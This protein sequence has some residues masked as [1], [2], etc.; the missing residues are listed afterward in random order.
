MVSMTRA[1]LYLRISQDRSGQQAGVKRQRQDCEALAAARGWEVAGVYQDNDVSAYSR[2]PRPEF[3]RLMDDIAAG[4]IDAVVA[5]ATDRLYRRT[6]DL[7]RLVD[8]L[9]GI[10]VATVKSGDVD[11]STAD[12]RLRA[13]ILA[14]VAQHE[15]EKKGERVKAAAEQRARAG[16]YG[17][18]ARRMGFTKTADELVPDEADA[19]RE[20]YLHV[21][22][23]GSLESVAKDWRTRLGTGPR[24][25]YLTGVQVRD[26]LLR[27]MNAG[28][29]T[30]LG[31]EV[32]RTNG[33]AIIDEDTFRTV[34]A[35]LTDPKRRTRR[36]RP[37][38]T[39]LSGIMR[40]QYCGRP[41]S[42]SSRDGGR[43][44]PRVYTYACR[45]RCVSRR[46]HRMDELITELVLTRLERDPEGFI[47]PAT[48]TQG[49]TENSAA[50]EA[51]K[52]RDRL[53]ALAQLFAAGELEATDYAA[54]TR[55]ARARLADL[56]TKLAALSGT[57]NAARLLQ[58]GDVR[59]AWEASSM[60]QRRAIIREVIDHIVVG[61]GTSG[62]F[63][64][65]GLEIA[66]RGS[67]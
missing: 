58:S 67:E 60:E 18:G 35:I 31:D 24:G 4:R 39:L 55:Q 59:Q 66:W 50:V 13:R 57:P 16:G 47:E 1:A 38:E 25:G 46:R 34:R 51:E 8:G 62:K 22:G 17:G 32:G 23:G 64:A 26:V 21:A 49:S 2:K 6:T 14:D 54:A 12:G 52:M 48:A 37:S 9:S 65:G 29:A 53:D 36:G 41:V 63:T 11:L 56:E 10:E 15:S 19:I 45:A 42:G 44:V 5:W 33:P 61:R 30:Y 28:I 40:C 43:K 20:A 3:E 27:P 7:D